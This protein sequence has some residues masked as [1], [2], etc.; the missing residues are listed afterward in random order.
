MTDNGKKETQSADENQP[1]MFF[2]KLDGFFRDAS[3]R[4]FL[5]VP[6]LRSVVI[7]YDFHGN[8][9]DTPGIPKGM[10]LHSEGGAEKPADSITGSAG[11][12]IQALAH[13]LD[14]QMSLYTRLTTELVE[15]S[16]AL[17]DAKN[18][19]EATE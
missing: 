13:M 10:W 14:E 7:V 9:N 5:S 16:K 4:G 15:V 11:A 12:T 17:V 1:L 3:Q 19:L 18:K 2:E 8:L 6:E